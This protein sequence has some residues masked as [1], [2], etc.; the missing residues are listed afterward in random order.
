MPEEPGRHKLNGPLAGV[1]PLYLNDISR[2]RMSPYGDSYQLEWVCVITY[3]F[4]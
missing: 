1:Y 3:L 4:A 2:G